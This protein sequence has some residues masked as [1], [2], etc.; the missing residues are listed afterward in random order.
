[1]MAYATA[2]VCRHERKKDRDQ[3]LRQAWFQA[4]LL[5][6]YRRLAACMIGPIAVRVKRVRRRICRSA[7][8]IDTYALACT[9]PALYLPTWSVNSRKAGSR[10][11]NSSSTFVEALQFLDA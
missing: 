3:S 9:L 6:I 4:A 1:M 8:A 7:V 5:R 2:Y 10:L 11:R